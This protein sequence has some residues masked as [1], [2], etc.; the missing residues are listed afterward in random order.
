MEQDWIS[1][2][3]AL[4]EKVGDAGEISTALDIPNYFKVERGITCKSLQEPF[5]ID[6]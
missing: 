1:V 5:A 3:L 6:H 4:Q 2:W